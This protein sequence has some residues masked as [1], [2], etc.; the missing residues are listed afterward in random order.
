MY[1]AVVKVWHLVQ[2]V[3]MSGRSR[4]GNS[5]QYQAEQQFQG[6][7]LFQGSS[8]IENEAPLQSSIQSIQI[9]CHHFDCCLLG[10]TSR[11]LMTPAA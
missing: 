11:H 4:H 7:L 2:P 10:E 1:L 9:A 6:G 5:P 8:P 3:M